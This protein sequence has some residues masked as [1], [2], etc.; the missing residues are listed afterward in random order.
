MTDSC[1]RGLFFQSPHLMLRVSEFVGH[2]DHHCQF[3]VAA[4]RCTTRL[5]HAVVSALRHRT[6]P[7]SCV[8]GRRLSF[9]VG[10]AE[11]TLALDVFW[12]TN[13]SVVCTIY[14]PW[15]ELHES[16][17]GEAYGMECVVRPFR[18]WL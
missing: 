12:Q 17:N 14:I 5:D 8:I 18:E 9:L 2:D 1:V 4:L 15:R 16:L 13:S 7:F 6:W 10:V 11:G 3:C